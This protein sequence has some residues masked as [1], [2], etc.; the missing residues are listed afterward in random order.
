MASK[1]NSSFATEQAAVQAPAQAA[2]PPKPKRIAP[3]PAA[4]EPLPPCGGAWLRAADGALVPQDEATAT[5]AGLAWDAADAAAAL[6]PPAP[7]A[8]ITLVTPI[9]QE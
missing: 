9:T 3:T 6:T 1:S 8:P 5:A 2:Q 7:P 4:P